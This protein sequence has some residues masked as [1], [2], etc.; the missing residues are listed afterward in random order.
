MSQSLIFPSNIE[1]FAHANISATELS[2]NEHVGELKVESFEAH[3]DNE[4]AS[5]IKKKRSEHE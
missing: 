1:K 4:D 2:K 5:S 3:A